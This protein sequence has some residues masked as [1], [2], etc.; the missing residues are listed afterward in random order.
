MC[1]LKVWMG[2]FFFV[3]VIDE[4]FFNTRFLIITRWVQTCSILLHHK[5]WYYFS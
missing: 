2:I 4:H 3:V 1:L 5:L